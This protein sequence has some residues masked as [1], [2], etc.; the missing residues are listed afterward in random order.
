MTEGSPKNQGALYDLWLLP[1]DG[2]RKPVPVL[3]TPFD[4]QGM[5]FS[6]DGRWVSYSSD[7]SSR[8]EVYVRAFNRATGAAGE[9]WQISTVG[10]QYAQ[11][12]GDGGDGTELFTWQATGRSWPWK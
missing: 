10:G 7:E 2:E 12:R 1:L 4:E 11:W 3:Q 9:K 6:P 8:A 5:R